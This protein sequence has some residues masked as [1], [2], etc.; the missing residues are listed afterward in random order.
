[1]RKK[2]FLL[3]MFGLITAAALADRNAALTRVAD[4]FDFPVGKPN[5]DGY[6][7]SRGFTP[8]GHLGEDWV[9]Q[10]G[11][12]ADF[13]DPVY[14]AGNGIVTLARDFRRAWGNVV[15][16]RHAFMEEGQVKYADSLYAH[17]DRILVR[18]GQQVV[19]G[20]QIGTIGNAHGLY[21]P[22]LHF[23]VHKNLAIGVVHTMFAGDYTNYYA[24]S[25]FINSHRKLTSGNRV[26]TVVMNN[27]VMPTFTGI[28]ALA[29]VNPSNTPREV[30]S[31]SKG[32]PNEFHWVR[33][34]DIT[35]PY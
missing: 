21:A 7:V 17:L 1:M 16:I 12:G 18:E 8:H 11:S 26:A 22:H 6:R 4:G 3:V 33:S 24:P 15:L 32:R 25:E 30:L 14:A 27:F 35:R 9:A 28:P 31:D 5:A 20:Q 2:S 19:R 29:P 23:E 13:R 10:G 34:E